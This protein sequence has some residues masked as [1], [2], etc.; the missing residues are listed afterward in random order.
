MNSK[1]R[2][3]MGKV[4]TP[5]VKQSRTIKINGE[6]GMD[7]SKIVIKELKGVKD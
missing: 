5:V 4:E 7:V 2:Y 6:H 3:S 1:S